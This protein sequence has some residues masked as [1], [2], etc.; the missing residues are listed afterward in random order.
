MSGKR[1]RRRPGGPAGGRWPAFDSSSSFIA[2]LDILRKARVPFALIG[3]LAVWEYVPPQRQ[4]FTKDVDF[5]VP[6]GFTPQV[7]Q[8]ARA[9]G[10]KSVSLDIG[11]CAIANKARGVAVD[12]IDRH[13]LLSKLFAEAIRKSQGNTAR[14]GGTSVPV[15][16]KE[17][18]VAM[19][20]ATSERDDEEDVKALLDTVAEREYPALRKFIAEKL[21]PL[22]ALRLDV[23]AREIGH[24]GVGR[25]RIYSRKSSKSR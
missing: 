16:R 22:A 24:H 6:Y 25:R 23:L 14:M 17:Y 18:L 8:A 9:A 15:V 12:F 7:A 11:G 4:I 10:Y 5:A 21:N 13:P 20:L 3:R 1:S 19:K 2:A